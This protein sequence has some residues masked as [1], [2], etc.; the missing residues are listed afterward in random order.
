M[1]LFIFTQGVFWNPNLSTTKYFQRGYNALI[2]FWTKFPAQLL[3]Q[4][5]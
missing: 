1:T 3:V 4:H 5:N 2:L